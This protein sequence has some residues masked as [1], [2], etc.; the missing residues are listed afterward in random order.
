MKS[1]EISEQESKLLHSATIDAINAKKVDYYIMRHKSDFSWMFQ[2][3]LK[4]VQEKNNEDHFPSK[5]I[6]T[7]DVYKMNTKFDILL[8]KAFNVAF[9]SLEN[10]RNGDLLR[11]FDCTTATDDQ[12]TK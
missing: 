10:I 3:I 2:D 11:P 8:D 1:K 7:V 4:Q 5:D 12:D 9:L 6:V